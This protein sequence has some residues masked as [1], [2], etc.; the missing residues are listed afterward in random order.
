MTFNLQ[1][2]HESMI[3]F[4]ADARHYPQVLDLFRD[5]GLAGLAKA[6][7]RFE[8][9]VKRLREES[10]KVKYEFLH[11]ADRMLFP[12][13]DG[14]HDHTHHVAD[15]LD[16]EHSECTHLLVKAQQLK[17]DFPREAEEAKHAFTEELKKPM[18]E[19][20][21]ACD[22]QIG[23]MMAYVEA[24]HRSIDETTGKKAE[25]ARQLK[26]LEEEKKANAPEIKKLR[27]VLKHLEKV[28][29]RELKEQRHWLSNLKDFRETKALQ[30]KKIESITSHQSY[31]AF[32]KMIQE[33]QGARSVI[34][35]RLAYHEPGLREELSVLR[36]LE[37]H[38]HDVVQGRA[39]ADRT[40]AENLGKIA[41]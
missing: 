40:F 7:V 10:L 38:L 35:Q 3:D 37:H 4:H 16:A 30:N 36:N 24:S 28:L 19:T 11:A 27:D 18:L 14:L 20:I 33:L 8:A 21:S 12:L 13:M 2:F 25:V 17:T 26:V 6:F 5:S 22:G 31:T 34:E 9:K 39:H 29:N 1:K 23:R 15:K 32:V 41:V